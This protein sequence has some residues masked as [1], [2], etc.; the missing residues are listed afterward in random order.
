MP[1]PIAKQR[2]A[3]LTALASDP[4]H[5]P[6]TAM[7]ATGWN[8]GALTRSRRNKEFAAMEVAILEG[9]PVSA[10]TS[11]EFIM[12]THLRMA[13]EKYL[14]QLL[15]NNGASILSCEESGLT[16]KQLEQAERDD[17]A[18]AEAQALVYSRI[19]EKLVDQAMKLGGL[20][21][22]DGKGPE[23]RDGNTLLKILA[24]IAPEDWGDKPKQVDIHYSGEVTLK[25]TA[26]QIMELLGNADSPED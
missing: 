20:R 13:K 6:R 4:K 9:H 18:F 12:Q 7:D 15:A 19:R 8:V 11:S 23:C 24:K 2:E 16:R 26:D 3:Y 21:G 17:P 1:S 14:V 10:A 22:P 5:L 25:S